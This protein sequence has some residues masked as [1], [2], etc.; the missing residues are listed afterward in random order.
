MGLARV[1]NVEHRT[2]VFYLHP[3]EVDPD[4]PRIEASRLSKFRH[5]NNLD[6]CEPRLRRLLADFPMGRMDHALAALKF[7]PTPLQLSAA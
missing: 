4:Q 3:W 1:N 2:F 7:S 6:K 5:Y